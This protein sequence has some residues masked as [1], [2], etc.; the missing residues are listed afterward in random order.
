MISGR[1][2]EERLGSHR[3]CGET[4]VTLLCIPK[5]LSQGIM[6]TPPGPEGTRSARKKGSRP[7]GR[8]KCAKTLLEREVKSQ[9][10]MKNVG[11]ILF[12]LGER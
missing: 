10:F 5:D 4:S 9:S 3:F 12:D 1:R 7:P 8:R 11:V 2:A 6:S